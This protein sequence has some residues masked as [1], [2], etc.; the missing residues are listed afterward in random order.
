MS[1]R[2]GVREDLD[3][4]FRHAFLQ[5]IPPF[6]K[7][8]RNILAFLQDFC[9]TFGENLTDADDRT[10][11]KPPRVWPLSDVSRRSGA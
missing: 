2:L 7:Y 10:I 1:R 3:L 8:L 6:T 11:T 5:T 4:Q 9:L